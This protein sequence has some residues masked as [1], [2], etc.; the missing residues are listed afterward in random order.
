MATPRARQVSASSLLQ[1]YVGAPPVPLLRCRHIGEQI[2]QALCA[3]FRR[4]ACARSNATN[5]I[6]S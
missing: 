3:L 5:A 4:M 6:A 1:E 2:A